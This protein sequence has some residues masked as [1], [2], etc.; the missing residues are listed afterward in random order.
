MPGQVPGVAQ[1][2]QLRLSQQVNWVIVA[3]QVSPTKGV[4]GEWTRTCRSS[5]CSAPTSMRG[6]KADIAVRMYQQLFAFTYLMVA[7][8]AC[9]PRAVLHSGPALGHTKIVYFFFLSLPC[10]SCVGGLGSY[11]LCR[12]LGV[13]G[14]S[15]VPG[16]APR[17]CH[18]LLCLCPP[19]DSGFDF[20][21]WPN[22]RA[23]K[24]LAAQASSLP[25]HLVKM[26]CRPT[27]N[28]FTCPQLSWHCQGLVEDVQHKV[29]AWAEP[30]SARP[31]EQHCADAWLGQALLV[32][33]QWRTF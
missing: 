1:W 12:E 24:Q 16:V 8:A 9:F 2:L 14:R 23:T 25:C 27:F 6:V 18:E 32:S 29:L 26:S 17:T 33:W 3:W 21:S 20:A 15:S 7:G 22:A 31:C 19:G 11:P 28:C 10:T 5:S 4:W 30:P 13:A